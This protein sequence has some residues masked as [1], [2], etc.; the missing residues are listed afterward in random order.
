MRPATRT[1]TSVSVPGSRAPNS[2]RSSAV[3]V[4]AYLVRVDAPGAQGL[5]VG[6]PACP[7]GRRV[8]RRRLVGAIGAVGHPADATC[9]CPRPS[10]ITLTAWS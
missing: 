5:Q 2:A 3:A 10:T 4:E 6:E 9:G 1:G 7:F 8:E